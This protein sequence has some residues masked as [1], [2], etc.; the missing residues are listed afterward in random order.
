MGVTING[1]G[2][3]Y[4]ISMSG[5]LALRQTPWCIA[6]WAR[7]PTSGSQGGIAFYARTPITSAE[8][9]IRLW[10]NP[11]L[12]SLECACSF[13]NGTIPPPPPPIVP[14]PPPYLSVG[15]T[16]ANDNEWRLFVYQQLTNGTQEVWVADRSGN[17]ASN[18]RIAAP[19]IVV[20]STDLEYYIGHAPLSTPE[21]F[22]GD[23]AEF[24]TGRFSLT[25]AQIEALAAG[26]TPVQIGKSPLAW[27]R[28]SDTSSTV[29]DLGTMGHEATLTGA[30]TAVP[31]ALPVQDSFAVSYAVQ[32]DW[33]RN[34]GYGDTHDDITRYVIG[35]T[36]NVGFRQAFQDVASESQLMVTLDNSDGRF[37][38][39]NSASAVYGSY[40]QMRPIRVQATYAGG[41]VTLW[42]GWTR[43]IQPTFGFEGTTATL[44]AVG[45]RNW[46]EN[47]NIRTL[48][49]E[50]YRSD[51]ILSEIA[52]QVVVPQAAP[53]GP[54]VLGRVGNSELGTTTA[55]GGNVLVSLFD[56]G[57]QT[58]VYAGDTWQIGVNA[59][60]AIEDV[61]RAER[62]RFYLDR[63]ARLVF[64]N[65][66]R[67]VLNTHIATYV[68]G[69]MQGM[70]YVYGAN[71]ANTVLVSVTPRTLGAG[72]SDVL[73]RLENAI[74][75][76][77]RG[78]KTISVRFNEQNSGV[79]IAGLDVVSPSRDDSSFITSHLGVT[80]R[81]FSA[82]ATG[83][84]IWLHNEWPVDATVTTLIVRGRKLA[85]FNQVVIE[86]SDQGSAFD[87]GRHTYNL[88]LPLLDDESMGRSIAHYEIARRKR[89]RGE[90]L[91]VTLLIRDSL[92][93]ANVLERVVGERVRVSD[94]RTGHDGQYHIVGEEHHLVP[95]KGMRHHEARWVLESAVTT[96]FWMLGRAGQSELGASARLGL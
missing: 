95:G 55:L 21:Y 77:A 23:I 66:Q 40:W 31:F 70:E 51:Q 28:F 52:A 9:F 58:F 75:I 82:Q 12:S 17:I 93:A 39:E 92:S 6:V 67:L 42:T 84:E 88:D 54:W 30:V 65:R 94:A 80:I 38:P 50:G 81:G 43:D 19:E 41:T 10:Y 74:K 11:L 36:W 78:E 34:G 32:V 86:V 27:M 46:V 71:L 69:T 57:A 16:F 64:W 1:A 56:T 87:Y 61:V 90:A 83:A 62:G 59:L 8:F 20:D 22:Y 44:T 18:N 68:A 60:D 96:T 33:N 14:P 35:A 76:P 48:L 24:F 13:A 53:N 72:A 73:W 45:G 26:Y 29:A 91:S 7:V 2:N 25:Q 15:R 5:G 63:Q 4:H 79:Q 3:H 49:M 85:T 89:P 37:S 47:V